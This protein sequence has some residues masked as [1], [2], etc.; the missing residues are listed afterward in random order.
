MGGIP[1]FFMISWGVKEDG[2]DEGLAVMYLNI[3]E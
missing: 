2:G 1:I 3:Y